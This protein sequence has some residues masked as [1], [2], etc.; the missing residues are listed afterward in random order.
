MRVPIRCVIWDISGCY[1]YSSSEQGSHPACCGIWLVWKEEGLK[2]YL[3]PFLIVSI[4][5]LV[6]AGSVVL[7]VWLVESLVRRSKKE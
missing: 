2:Y 4:A 1:S 3:G 6:M 7:V 5:V